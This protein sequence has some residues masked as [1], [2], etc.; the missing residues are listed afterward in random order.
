MRASGRQARGEVRILLGY[1]LDAVG[2]QRFVSH[3]E[4]LTRHMLHT[5]PGHADLVLQLDT[6]QHVAGVRIGPRLAS[7]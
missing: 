1:L 4:R 5:L 6:E 2:L 3:Y 7:G